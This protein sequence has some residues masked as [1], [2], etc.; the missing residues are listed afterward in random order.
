[1]FWNLLA[2]R[3]CRSCGLVFVSPR[4]TSAAMRRVFSD[5]YFELSEP[6]YWGS[7][8]EP[9]FQDILRLLRRYGCR[10]VFDVGTAFGHFVKWLGQ[11]GVAASGCEVSRKAV[12]WGRRHLGVTLYHGALGDLDLPP[13][14]FDGVVCLDT[15]YYL[16]DPAEELRA[17]GRLLKPGGHLILRLRT[18]VG[19]ATRAR[20]E[21]RRSVGR[22]VLPMPHLWAFSPA[23][24]AGVLRAHRFDVLL[25]EPA[26]YSRGF[27]AALRWIAVRTHRSVSHVAPRLPIVTGSFNLVGRRV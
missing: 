17:M 16:A 2:L 23:T 22:P 18:N 10:T 21:G 14:S 6:D 13:A 24:V 4:L 20:R 27:G 25:C 5:C 7:R 12:E 15:L 1:M 11:H 3:Q 8:R 26:A 9:V 19:V